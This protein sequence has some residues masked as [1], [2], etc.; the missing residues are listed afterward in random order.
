MSALD[1][2]EAYLEPHCRCEPEEGHCE[3]CIILIQI[4]DEIDLLKAD[5]DRQT[6]VA[7]ALFDSLATAERTLRAISDCRSIA[8]VGDVLNQYDARPD[9]SSDAPRT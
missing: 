7:S 9:T 6:A 8:E 3:A 5:R 2:L 1:R 4:E